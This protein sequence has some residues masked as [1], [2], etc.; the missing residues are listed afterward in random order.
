MIW[1]NIISLFI[2]TFLHFVPVPRRSCRRIT[3]H[4]QHEAVFQFYINPFIRKVKLLRIN[5]VWPFQKQQLQQY[6][7]YAITTATTKEEVANFLMQCAK[8]MISAQ[9]ALVQCTFIL[10]YL[11]EA[12]H[13]IMTLNY[14]L[15][16]RLTLVICLTIHFGYNLLKD[17]I[18]QNTFTAQPTGA[19]HGLDYSVCPD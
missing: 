1:K 10:T 14:Y 17:H 18:L 13:E 16:N 4:A 19:V 6:G 7:A 3:R 5:G 11:F 2:N 8:T 12:F 9:V 15:Y